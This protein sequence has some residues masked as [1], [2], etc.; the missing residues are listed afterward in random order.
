MAMKYGDEEFWY[1]QYLAADKMFWNYLHK[2]TDILG[3]EYSKT[4]MNSA[5][6]TLEERFKKE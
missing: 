5:I 6:S 2:L 1:N 3:L 4:S